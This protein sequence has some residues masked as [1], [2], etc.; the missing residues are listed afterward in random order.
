MLVTVISHV[1]VMFRRLAKSAPEVHHPFLAEALHL[2][3]K[4]LLEA[5][6]VEEAM[7]IQDEAVGIMRHLYRKDPEVYSETLC[8]Y[9]TALHITRARLRG[10][11]SWELTLEAI[12]LR[13]IAYRTQKSLH[14]LDVL[15]R[16]L[17][18]SAGYLRQYLQSSPSDSFLSE[19]RATMNEAVVQVR[20]HPEWRNGRHTLLP[21]ALQCLGDYL[22]NVPDHAAACAAYQEVWDFWQQSNLERSSDDTHFLAD[23][24][25]NYYDSLKVLGRN[26]KAEWV[27]KEIIILGQPPDNLVILALEERSHGFDYAVTLMSLASFFRERE[28]F[29]DACIIEKKLITTMRD[30]HSIYKKYRIFLIHYLLNHAFTLQQ[31]HQWTT[32]HSVV[33]EAISL[34]AQMPNDFRERYLA[35]ALHQ[36]GLFFMEMKEDAK[37]H[38]SF[39][40]ACEASL[41]VVGRIRNI[42]G[43]FPI[44]GDNHKRP[45]ILGRALH[46]SSALLRVCGRSQEA[47]ARYS[48]AIEWDY[49]PQSADTDWLI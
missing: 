16:A 48:E 49:T 42:F 34:L 8:L 38:Q 31:L 26:V 40:E 37:A 7:S 41:N 21:K 39:V 18:D 43:D 11:R 17:E 14:H 10:P 47:D 15:V 5:R 20:D 24:L 45:I 6:L 29:E 35:R 44:E 13:T 3:G 12:S 33:D 22:Q 36:R 46:H 28:R 23:V 30:H 27:V 4:Y 2:Y 9:L 19:T 1:V 32:G 25:K